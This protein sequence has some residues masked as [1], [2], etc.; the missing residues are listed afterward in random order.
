[1]RNSTATRLSD[2][3]IPSPTAGWMHQGNAGGQRRQKRR[4][5]ARG[6]RAPSRCHRRHH[7]FR[8]CDRLRKRSVLSR[9]QD[10]RGLPGPLTELAT[11][12]GFKAV[13]EPYSLE[14]E[15]R[16]LLRADFVKVR[17]DKLAMRQCTL[18]LLAKGQSSLSP[19]SRA[20]MR[21]LTI[22]WT[23]SIS[24]LRKHPL[25]R[26]R[27]SHFGLAPLEKHPPTT[28][29]TPFTVSVPASE[30]PRFVLK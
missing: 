22:S 19:S 3:A 26:L 5:A 8:G 4:P 10:S 7:Q 25:T 12:K 23:V 15:S 30:W 11:A 6:L 20:A 24:S 2:S 14:V 17:S 16:Q 9:P 18:V 13:G 27:P 21:N 1:M 29:K 28:Q